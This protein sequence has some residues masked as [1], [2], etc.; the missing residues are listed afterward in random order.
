M[1][2]LEIWLRVT[3]AV[4]GLLA[5]A[6]VAAMLTAFFHLSRARTLLVEAMAEAL[7]TG[8]CEPMSE[9]GTEH[10]DGGFDHLLRDALESN[11]LALTPRVREANRLCLKFNR[12]FN[13][14]VTW[15]LIVLLAGLT[16]MLAMYIVVHRGIA[17]LRTNFF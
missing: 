9:P 4:V 15:L 6:L 13:F 3:G 2:A 16:V 12:Q 7:R 8:G 14:A 17:P 11:R 5:I 1:S 10:Y